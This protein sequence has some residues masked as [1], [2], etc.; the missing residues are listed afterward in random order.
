MTAV[1]RDKIEMADYKNILA[2]DCAT[3]EMKLGLQFGG[4]RLVKSNTDAKQS[5][6][7][8]IVKKI[9][10]LLASAGCRVADIDAIVVATGPGSFTG[11]RI[12]IACAKGMGSA[13][14]I[15]VV[16]VNQFE[17][18]AY[19]L[20]NVKSK[21][22]VIVPFKKDEVFTGIVENGK[23][24]AS[25]IATVSKSDL[26][27]HTD[28]IKSAVMGIDESI[29]EQIRQGESAAHRGRESSGFESVSC[30]ATELIYLG[31]E[32]LNGGAIPD[33]AKLEPLYVQQ[34]QAEIK[35]ERHQSQT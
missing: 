14:G 5:H 33:L 2:I 30:D 18:A 21:V 20:T 19:K 4:D 34:S 16:G 7:A 23:F 13:L 25:S 35:F 8:L 12:G 9:Q 10:S 22:K 26:A 29:L 32:K 3:D 1:R 17:L 27:R 6:S 31:V 11:L 28:G 24:D 15:P